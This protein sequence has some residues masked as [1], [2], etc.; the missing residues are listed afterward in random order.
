MAR[1]AENPPNPMQPSILIAGGAGFIGSNF[2][3]TLLEVSA[4]S[5]VTLDKCTYATGLNN[6][7][8]FNDGG[9]H[10]FVQGDIGNRALIRDLLRE[11]RPATVVNFAAET[12]VDRSILFPEEF[13]QTNVVGTFNLLDE[14]RQYWEG[15]PGASKD[16][17]RFLQVST[18]EVY[19]SLA[20]SD[21]PCDENS[22]FAP[23][24]PY[25]AS[26]A[27]ADQFVRAF[28][29]T[30]GVPTQIARCCNNYGPGQYP[31]KLIPLVILKALHEQPLPIFGDGNQIRDWLYV[32]DHCLAL[33]KIIASGL[34][35]EV[36]NISAR[37]ERTNLQVV[38]AICALLDEARPRKSGAYADLIAHV[39]DRPGHDRRYALDSSK[40]SS[41]LDWRSTESFESGLEKTVRWYLDHMDQVMTVANG[42][43]YRD[44][45]AVSYDQRRFG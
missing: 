44:W 36:Y 37:A 25:A 6:L 34:P 31:E 19:G 18:D 7:A 29:Q 35:G 39:T 1:A 5:I 41:Q 30:Y 17:F 23:N 24:S 43:A 45:L 2:V 9:R 14:V 28:H 21:P 42:R 12:H 10:H 16:N 32:R 11:H 20:P 22:A 4:S 13:V 8:E 27:A 38:R 15:L 40:I 26:K 3:R 33:L